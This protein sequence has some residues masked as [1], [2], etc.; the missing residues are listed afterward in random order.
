MTFG[1]IFVTKAQ[2]N[3]VVIYQ[4]RKGK[5]HTKGRIEKSKS[6]GSTFPNILKLDQLDCSCC[7]GD[8]CPER[9]LALAKSKVSHICFTLDASNGVFKVIGD[10]G[11]V[12]AFA[13][14]D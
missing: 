2:S 6:V 4:S 13:S 3:C 5:Y 1:T 11:T 10:N 8:T 14:D 12:A 9:A 7:H